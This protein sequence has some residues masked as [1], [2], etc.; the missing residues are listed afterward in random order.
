VKRFMYPFGA[1]TRLVPTVSKGE[2][3]R[4]T[5]VAHCAHVSVP[6]IQ[7]ELKPHAAEPIPIIWLDNFGLEV[8]STV[9]VLKKK[10]TTLTLKTKTSSLHFY[11][12]PGAFQLQQSSCYQQGRLYG[13]DVSSGAAVA[14]LLC[15]GEHQDNTSPN[16][17][18]PPSNSTNRSDE[19][20]QVL[21]LCC[22]PGLKLCMIADILEQQQQQQ[23][24]NSRK[25]EV[26]QSTSSEFM[27]RSSL[28]HRAIGVD[29]SSNRINICKKVVEKYF[30]D[31]QT[32]GRD[33]QQTK[34]NIPAIPVKSLT[35]G[36]TS[37]G[38][39]ASSPY[40]PSTT[41]VQLFCCDGT[42]FGSSIAN[43]E[44]HNTEQ[45]P[46]DID[47][48]ST[49]SKPQDMA[50][51]S[52]HESG[53]VWDSF[54]AMEEEIESSSK[55]GGAGQKRKRKN[56][57]AR[58]RERQRLR[59]VVVSMSNN[60]RSG[61]KETNYNSISETTVELFDRVL[62]DAECSTDGAIRH[63]QHK[64]QKEH[65]SS[66]N[67][68]TRDALASPLTPPPIPGMDTNE[69]EPSI[70]ENKA[71]TQASELSDLV[72]LQKRL[73]ESGFRLLKAGGVMVYSTCSLS[74]DQNENVVAHLL[75]KES[76]LASIIPVACPKIDGLEL[77]EATFSEAGSIPG[78][79]R[80][81]PNLSTFSLPSKQ[82][83]GGFFLAK[84]RKKP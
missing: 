30:V 7:D 33:Q 72:D 41:V 34:T 5:E 69:N 25:E 1:T 9:D 14:A 58:S 12:L 65:G 21:D 2:H 29:L 63:L 79:V 76:E 71:L 77:E 78:T 8:S 37:S 18:T 48:S 19:P 4:L 84:I 45:M 6:S 60:Q 15:D 47:N 26:D 74:R 59:Q 23:H 43:N 75:E 55:A 20:F 38:P 13:M 70:V 36:E 46:G 50:L 83:G 67:S 35:E 82:F 24:D 73:I 57:S 31:S 52:L 54:C 32:S 40:T 53:F 39:K 56:K 80:F 27:A 11:S 81:K 44:S 51:E 17:N 62:V 10:P 28:T 16:N 49:G 64:L 61:E 42:T 22:A 68:G 66:D 3:R